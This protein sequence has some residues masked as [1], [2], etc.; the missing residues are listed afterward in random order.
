MRESKEV[1]RR[2]KSNEC[3]GQLVLHS[4]IP[5]AARMPRRVRRFA[6]ILTK[7]RIEDRHRAA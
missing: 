2:L 5:T 1:G 7:I 6:N 4:G 3:A